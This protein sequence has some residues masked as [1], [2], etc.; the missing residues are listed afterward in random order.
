M[1]YLLDVPLEVLLHITSHLTTPEYGYLRR[2]CKQL[3][4]LLFGAFAKE[5]FTKRQFS[6]TEFSIQALVDIS[7]SRLGPSIEH[8]IIH[9]EHPHTAAYADATSAI[10]LGVA[11]RTMV[12]YNQYY[13][14][15][16]S[17]TEF[18]TTGL[19][20]EMLSDAVKH[21]PNLETIG[22][23][24]FH[25]RNRHRDN[26]VWNSYG[27]VTLE[28]ETGYKMELP[29]PTPSTL[30][31]GPEYASYVFLTILRAV[32]NGV[33]SGSNPKLTRMEVLLH[34]CTFRDLSFKI[35]DRFDAS[36]SSALKRFNVILLDNLSEETGYFHAAD[37]GDGTSSVLASGYCLSRFLAK[38]SALQHLRLNF[39]KYSPQSTERFLLW[40][41]GAGQNP[42]GTAANTMSSLA[43]ANAS[44]SLPTHFPPTP[45]SWDLK[46]ID[47]GMASVTEDVLLSVYKRYKT[48]LRAIS[49]HKIT[50]LPPAHT[51]ANLWAHLCNGMV[52][53]ELELEELMLSDIRQSLRGRLTRYGEVTFEGNQRSKTWTGSA[54]SQAIKDITD[55]MVPSW[56]S[57][58]SDADDDDYMDD[59]EGDLDSEEDDD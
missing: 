24:D 57:G 49:L 20:V 37:S 15:S 22:M 33:V 34:T 46:R 27:T 42:T 4:V 25:S 47:I 23:R 54:F 12:Q 51:K 29:Y 53:G 32:G 41:A 14:E 26:T 31:R 48:T 21:L 18:I 55:E 16:V 30:R 40:L 43:S 13:A 7:K 44:G 3:E 9:L 1:A 35:P 58:D 56:N 19:D 8:L 2:A 59:D 38:A 28:K 52:K 45:Q 50:L 5:F 11:P 39:Q 17:H 6:L 36:I 10:R